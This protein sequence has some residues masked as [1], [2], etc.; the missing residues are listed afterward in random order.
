MSI[1]LSS[2]PQCGHRLRLGAVTCEACGAA[3]PAINV[4]IIFIFF[5]LF[6]LAFAVVGTVLLSI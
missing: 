1:R 6:A 5:V 3:V 2:C 4:S